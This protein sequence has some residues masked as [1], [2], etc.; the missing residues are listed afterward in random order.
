MVTTNS[1]T[2]ASVRSILDGI[3]DPEIPVLTIADIGMLRDVR[4]AD[5]GSVTV[6]IT[7]TYSGCPA[8]EV[9]RSDI[10]A[11]L[12]AEGYTASVEMVFSPAWTTEWMT[13]EAKR[14]LAGY[15]IAP[16]GSVLDIAPEVLCPNCSESATRVVSEF[17]STA[18]KRLMVCTSCGE[19]FDQFKEI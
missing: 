7:P 12:S 10:L 8:M 16:P 2:E 4:V 1:D 3:T 11:A 17:G 14:K 6:H 9:I 5:D 18:C 15:G 13:P 19:P